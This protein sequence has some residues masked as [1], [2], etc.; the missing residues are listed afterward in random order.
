M[1]PPLSEA[2]FSLAEDPRELLGELSLP[3][4]YGRGD[5]MPAGSLGLLLII[6]WDT[7]SCHVKKPRLVPWRRTQH[8]TPADSQSSV[9]RQAP[10]Y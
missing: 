4:G 8:V 1:E 10:G 5:T 6:S 3:T 2:R 7:F 9:Q